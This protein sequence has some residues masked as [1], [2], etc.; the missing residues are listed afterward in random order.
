MTIFTL[1]KEV[2]GKG[3]DQKRNAFIFDKEDSDFNK[4]NKR[5][6]IWL[7]RIAL[8]FCN[9]DLDIDKENGRERL[10]WKRKGRLKKKS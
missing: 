10:R 6:R 1:I 3:H 8:L 7:K 4:G 9:E 2:T 5:K